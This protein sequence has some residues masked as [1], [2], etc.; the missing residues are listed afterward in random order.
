M[1]AFKLLI[2]EK[3][4]KARVPYNAKKSQYVLIQFEVMNELKL[5]V[6]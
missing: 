3:T 6:F 4:N 2:R 5:P 1:S